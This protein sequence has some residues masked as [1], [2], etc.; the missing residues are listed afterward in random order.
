MINKT[1]KHIII[2]LFLFGS[3]TACQSFDK[4]DNIIVVTV[5]KR[6]I[7]EDEL[8]QDV[9][10]ISLEMGLTEQ[11]T[12]QDIKS[13]IYRVLDNYLILEYGKEKKI[14]ISNEELEAAV[15]N[16]TKD[17]PDDVFQ[18]T[19]LSRYIDYDRWKES[20]RQ[21][22]LIRKI[23]TSA[24]AGLAP[25][26]FEETK[27][28]FDS[29]R[30]TF[31]RPQ[32]VELRQVVTREREEAETILKKLTEDSDMEELARKHSITP[33]ADKGGILGWI[34]QGELDETI[35]KSIFSV[36]VGSFTSVLQ[37]PYGFHIFKV[38]AERPEGMKELPEVITEI[39]AKLF[40]QKRELFYIQ[41]LSQLRETFP[42]TIDEN[43]YNDWSLK[44]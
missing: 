12:I 5:G 34:A 18:E 9:Q 38:L 37:S 6:L 20:V 4:S 19:L 2:A 14:T 8:K 1:Y 32:M 22:L 3:L 25:V 44:G 41:W 35:E 13:L 26:S 17:Y 15:R 29:H 43:I 28:Y 10:L 16:L 24:T 11:E 23:I 33:E 42:V 40:Q 21:G 30:D 36:P 27:N 7:S 39:E 31:K